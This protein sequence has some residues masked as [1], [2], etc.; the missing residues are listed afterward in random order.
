M[1]YLLG[2]LIVIPLLFSGCQEDDGSNIPP[3]EERREKAVE[4]LIEKLT[5]PQNGW[6]TSYKPNP[7]SG[8]FLILLDF[9]EDGE[10]TIKSD[11][12]AEQG[13]YREQTSTYRIDVGINLELVFETFGVFHYFFELGNTAFGGEFEFYFTGEQGEDLLFVSKT[14]T[15]FPISGLLLQPADGTEEQFLGGEIVD[16]FDEY[17]G[18]SPSIFGIKSPSQQLVLADKGISVFWGLDVIGRSLFID[19]VAEGTSDEEVRTINNIQLIGQPSSYSFVGSSIVLNEPVS[20]DFMGEAITLSELELGNFDS[21]G[22][23]PLC[24]LSDNTPLYTG[25]SSNGS[26]SVEKSLLNSEGLGF[27][28][29]TDEIYSINSFFIF[30]D[31]LRSLQEEG[32]ISVTFPTALGFIMTYGYESDSLPANSVGLIYENEFEE[33]EWILQH[34]ESTTTEMNRV[35]IRLKDEYFTIGAVDQDDL[36]NM[37]EVNSEIFEGGVVYVYDW[38]NAFGLKVWW[39]YNPCNEYELLLV[40]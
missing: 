24:V 9:N 37:N 12:A 28:P 33:N 2:L 1:R 16:N 39:F 10:V 11:I 7:A 36:D 22:G 8:A 17:G 21:N 35:E 30:D 20:F 19:F 34:I 29:R 40:D 4:D 31:S 32:V 18:N 23:P 14:D 13:Y 15:Q 3:P 5:A 27:Q 26:V 6:I 38:E 25:T